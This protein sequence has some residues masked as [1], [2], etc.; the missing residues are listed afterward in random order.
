V[1]AVTP[2]A[3]ASGQHANISLIIVGNLLSSRQN[4]MEVDTAVSISF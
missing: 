4:K 3:L 2:Q 1:N